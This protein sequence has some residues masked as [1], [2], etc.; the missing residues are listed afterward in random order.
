MDGTEAQG[1]SILERYASSS[2]FLSPN[3]NMDASLASKRLLVRSLTADRSFLCVRCS[4][5]SFSVV[6][7]VADSPSSCISFY[8][9]LHLR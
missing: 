6:T 7:N 8:A 3:S 9:P 1:H 4:R 5:Y 2:L